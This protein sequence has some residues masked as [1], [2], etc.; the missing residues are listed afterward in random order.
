MKR[1]H[2]AHFAAAILVMFAA[3][4]ARAGLVAPDHVQWSYN[5]TPSAGYVYADTSP[6]ASVSFT[7]EKPNTAQGNS[8]V[9]VTN[10][11]VSSTADPNHPD[12]LMNNGAYKIAMV[13][14]T[15][16]NGSPMSTTLYF[17]GKLSG[18]FSSASANVTNK[19]GP[20]ATQT[21]VFGAYTFTVSVDAYTPPGPPGSL[22]A[23]SVSAHVSITS[24]G[25]I[26]E[27]PEPSTMLLS[28]LGLTFLGGAAWRKRRLARMAV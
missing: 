19:F 14:G 26:A 13:L 2:T 24:S 4:S 7:N 9:D 16:A 20:D 17:T 11:R 1:F 18:S 5:F 27:T 15:S 12:A 28:G 25:H 10:L 23:G 3:T 21:V 8:D 6:T 22:N